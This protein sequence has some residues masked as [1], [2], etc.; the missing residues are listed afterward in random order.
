VDSKGTTLIKHAVADDVVAKDAAILKMVADSIACVGKDA[1]GK[2]IYQYSDEE[3]QMLV[4]GV[5]AALS[6]RFKNASPKPDEVSN[7]GLAEKTGIENAVADYFREYRKNKW[8]LKGNALV[9]NVLANLAF[10]KD[11]EVVAL[12]AA[13]MPPLFGP[14]EGVKDDYEEETT[15]FDMKFDAL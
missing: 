9:G 12:Y 11:Y 8:A 10:Q 1:K 3:F 6:K 5:T 15:L 4:E 2:P 13:H 14:E 7:F